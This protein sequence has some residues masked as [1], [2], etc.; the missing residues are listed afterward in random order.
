[1]IRKKI[2]SLTIRLDE[3]LYNAINKEAIRTQNSISE[4]IRTML[5]IMVYRMKLK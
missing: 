1:M 2:K 3:E 5:Y 4:T